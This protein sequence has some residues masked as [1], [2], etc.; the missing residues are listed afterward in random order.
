MDWTDDAIVLSARKHGESSAIVQLLTA[1]RGRHAGLVRG[2]AGRAQR[3]T[4]QP[5]NLVRA[6]WQARLEDHLGGY[7]CELVRATAAAVFEDRGRLAALSSACAV[8]EAA[9]P[10]REPHANIHAD[11]RALLAALEAADEGAAL[12]A[13]VRWEVS[14]LADLGFGLDLT[15]CGATGSEENL[16]YVSPR[17]GRA[18]SAAAGEPYKDRLLRLP[19]FLVIADEAPLRS[20]LAAGL[21]LSGHFL[22]SHVLA[23]HGRTLPPARLRLLD[24]LNAAAPP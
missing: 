21:L 10:E 22:D 20:E 17:T 23:P 14:L 6:H 7:R 16:I 13:Y 8:V 24:S 19:G 15:R 2:G 9:L 5:G 18:V 3:G 4:L 12:A 1:E 11:T